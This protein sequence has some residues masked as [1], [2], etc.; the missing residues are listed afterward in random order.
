M[1]YLH[2]ICNTESKMSTIRK[3]MKAIN[4]RAQRFS[5]TAMISSGALSVN[6]KKHKQNIH[7]ELEINR[8]LRVS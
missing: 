6:T 4:M 7:L 2:T 1:I 3:T 5:I 8:S